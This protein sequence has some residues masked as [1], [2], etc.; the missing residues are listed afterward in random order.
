M[1]LVPEIVDAV[2]P[3]PVLLRVGSAVDAKPLLPWRLGRKV[4]GSAASG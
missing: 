2:H 1:V 3:T 4:C